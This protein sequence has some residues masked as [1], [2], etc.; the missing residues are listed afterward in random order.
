MDL[1]I[2]FFKYETS[3]RSLFINFMTSLRTKCWS[4]IRWRNTILISLPQTFLLELRWLLL[5]KSSVYIPKCYRNVITFHGILF[6]AAG[7]WRKS[8]QW[9]FRAD[10]HIFWQWEIEKLESWPRCGIGVLQSGSLHLTR[11]RRVRWCKLASPLLRGG[12]PLYTLARNYSGPLFNIRLIDYGF[13]LFR[14]IR[15]LEGLPRTKSTVPPSSSLFQLCFRNKTNYHFL[16]TPAFP[17]HERREHDFPFYSTHLEPTGR[18]QLNL[19]TDD[20]N[21]F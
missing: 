2:F 5:P 18:S 8:S 15:R 17:S 6:K 10:R 1:R 14:K 19:Q 3:F 9:K 7:T 4:F 13:P 16:R 21:P 20:L 11:R 12:R